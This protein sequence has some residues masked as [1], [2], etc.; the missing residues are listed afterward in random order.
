MKYDSF[1]PLPSYSPRSRIT[2]P[3]TEKARLIVRSA[4]RSLLHLCLLL[5]LVPLFG[6]SRPT[7]PPPERLTIATP[8]VIAAA[9]LVIAAQRGLFTAQGLEVTLIPSDTSPE[10]LSLLASGKADGATAADMVVAESAFHARD[11]RIVA[12][13]DHSDSI[14]CVARTDRG[15][16]SPADLRGKRLGIIPGT[17]SEYYADLFL[18]VNNLTFADVTPILFGVKELKAAFLKGEVDA[19]V[20]WSPAAG[21]IASPPPPTVSWPVQEGYPLIFV[22]SVSRHLAEQRPATLERLV[23]GLAAA[24][25]LVERDP[26]GCREILAQW[27]GVT[28]AYLAAA[29][30]DH[31]FGVYLDRALMINLEEQARWFIQRRRVNA[32]TIPN[33]LEFITFGPLERVRPEAVTIIR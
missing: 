28:P 27:L 32:V 5:A 17:S 19:V 18:H 14:R 16:R 7:P 21:E 25:E 8:R 15:I 13:I 31:D 9:L 6:C 24:E 29:W 12:A 26:Q 3:A 33:F 30:K 11:F 23:R 4:W 10:A 22:L 1:P 2:S 20:V